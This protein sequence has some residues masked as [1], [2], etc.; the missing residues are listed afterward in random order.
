MT[1]VPPGARVF[2]WWGALLFATSLAV[3]VYAYFVTFGRPAPAGPWLR[4]ALFNVGLFSVF[5]LHHSALARARP[6]AWMTR[7]VSP[8]LERPVYVWIASVLLISVCLLWRPVPGELY[9]IEGAPAVLLRTLQIAAIVMTIFASSSVGVWDLAGVAHLV[10]ARR[11]DP[12][13]HVPLR[14]TGLYGMVRHPLYF[15]WSILVFS[16]PHMTMTRFV[17]ATVSTAYLAIAVPFEER[18]LI[19]TFGDD[20]R[21]YRRQVR[22]RMLPGLY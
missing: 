2:A 13:R 12:P 21:T 19:S 20:Y 3:F 16:A 22:W 9:R 8:A 10:D 7:V 14:T 18:G 15:A 5:A 17:F 11:A 4:N 1:A 6:K